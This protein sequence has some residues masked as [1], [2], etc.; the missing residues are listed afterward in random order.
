MNVLERECQSVV[1][2]L[3]G[4]L[5]C[6]VVDPE[7]RRVLAARGEAPVT[8]DVEGALIAATL[9][10]LARPEASGSSHAAGAPS[11]QPP[12]AP[13]FSEMQVTDTR[14]RYFGKVLADGRR[15][16]VLV[17]HKDANAGLGW[18]QLKAMVVELDRAE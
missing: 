6:G 4:V 16:A 10:L 12:L 17:T 18:A 3:D 11:G 15:V 1:D 14:T 13:P 7:T 2:S 9:E 8:S 5:I